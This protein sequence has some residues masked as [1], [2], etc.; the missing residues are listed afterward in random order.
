MIVTL[1]SG[2]V[3]QAHS[4]DKVQGE[5]AEEYVGYQERERD[6]G[7]SVFIYINEMTIASVSTRTFRRKTNKHTRGKI[8]SIC[9]WTTN[10]CLPWYPIHTQLRGGKRKGS[11]GREGLRGCVR[12]CVRAFFIYTVTTATKQSQQL[13]HPCN[14]NLISRCPNLMLSQPTTQPMSSRGWMGVEGQ[15]GF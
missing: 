15:A 14:S 9:C 6:S 11:F 4:Y 2:V 10:T 5:E 13:V 8:P 3:L 12:M 7:V 1:E